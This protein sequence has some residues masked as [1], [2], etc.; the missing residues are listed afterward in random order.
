VTAP[1]TPTPAPPGRPA[2]AGRSASGGHE[3]P[4][5]PVHETA[6]VAARPFERVVALLDAAFDRAYGSRWS[7]AQQSGALAV[8]FMLVAVAT[9]VYLLFAYRIGSPYESMQAIQAQ[10]WGGRWLRALHRY[11]SDLAVAAVAFHALRML[12]EGRSWGP[13]VL[14]WVTG[15][16]LTG[17]MLVVGWTGYVL[18]W[19][20]HG[21]LLGA[22]GAR[23][24]D[25][26]RVLA[27]PI[28]RIFSGATP[29]PASFFFLNL[30]V[31]MALPLAMVLLLW[32]H[33]LRLARSR[34]LPDRRLWL[35]ATAAAT[36]L[37]V[38]WPATLGPAADGLTLGDRAAYD[39][40][41]TA[42]IPLAQRLPAAVA[43]ATT[44]ALVALPLALPLVWR[45]RR[46][47]RAE[48]ARHNPLACNGCT[49]CAQDCPFEAISMVPNT[50]GR[51]THAEIAFVHAARCVSC[52]LCSGSCDQLAIGPPGRDGRAQAVAV[53]PLVAAADPEAFVLMHCAHDGAGGAL[54]ERG[55]AGGVRLIVQAVDCV[56]SLHALPVQQLAER[57]RGVFVLG[58]PSGRCRSREGVP[59]ALG[60]LLQGREPFLKRPLD[61]SRVRFASGGAADLAEL[62]AGLLRF[63]REAGARAE[64]AGFEAGRRGP[65]GW[66]FA[67]LVTA[68]LLAA[69]G[70]LSQVPA[71][72]APAGGAVRL[73]WRLPG[74]SWL[75]CR[76]LP[77]EEIAKLPA[78]MRR[79][80]DCRTVY[81]HYRLRAWVDGE[82]RV[83]REVAPLGARGDR[84]LYVEQDLRVAPGERE[85]R[86]EFTP[87]NDPRGAGLALRLEEELDVTAGRARLVTYD[88]DEKRLRVR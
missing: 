16:V 59:L 48:P 25:S 17:S 22:A 14:A 32:V 26:L 60:R 75:D 62:E 11:T 40:F 4:D 27:T 50:T 83:D 37:S 52:G 73:A 2:R 56:G 44:I 79:T 77:L 39:V 68:L 38:L 51:G 85:L 19:D 84:P 23:L 67:T 87:L 45:P 86:V 34:W 13:R 33:T 9:G 80:D 70:W 5:L 81:L 41:Y 66:V 20:E 55:R 8:A 28:G 21:R 64:P 29:A 42:W 15:L 36:V 47:R 65:L 76:P 7:P 3:A 74:Q 82:L 10:V 61:A 58:C 18:V 57:H 72:S 88:P 46:E 53:R 69:T 63:S 43:W 30:F 24:M 78:H 71:G 6:P 49:Q 54:A 12:A 35:A 1:V 31:H